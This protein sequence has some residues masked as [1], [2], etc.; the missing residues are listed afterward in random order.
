MDPAVA[1]QGTTRRASRPWWRLWAFLLSLL[2]PGL[3]Q[4]FN[5]EYGRGVICG[6]AVA[7]GFLAIKLSG[8]AWS[9]SPALSFSIFAVSVVLSLVCWFG[10][11]I[12]AFLRT[13]AAR[14]RSVGLVARFAIYFAFILGWW[15]A[16]AIVSIMPG[17]KPYHAASE[18]MLP[19]LDPGDT[20]FVVNG[21][22]HSH[23]PQRGDVIVFRLARDPSIE[24][25][26][27]LVG[28]PGD[29]MQMRDGI[30]YINDVPLSR[31]QIEDFS[32]PRSGDGRLDRYRQFSES[33]AAR[34]PYRII[35]DPR[36]AKDLDNTP[37]LTVPAAHYF[38]LGDNRDNSVDSRYP[39]GDV[40]FV[41]AENIVGKAVF[42]CMSFDERQRRTAPQSFL[43]RID[44]TRTGMRLD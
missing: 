4:A 44:W 17:L 26:K 12:D 24:F 5:Q 14:S 25:I 6:V 33:V 1:D 41:P 15:V 19:T 23:P 37:V 29:R 22:Y 35:M 16:A 39:K 31:A 10:T 11:G 34:S 28:Y 32:Y 27:R 21:Y 13:N 2:M 40:G 38:V 3:G 20:F 42:I 30:L 8:L 9:L 7:G 18:S 36:G 43:P